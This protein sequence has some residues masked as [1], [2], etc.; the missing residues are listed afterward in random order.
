MNTISKKLKLH[1]LKNGLEPKQAAMILNV[2]E[3]KYLSFEN[4]NSDISVVQLLRLC[5]YYGLDIAGFMASNVKKNDVGQA[6]ISIAAAKVRY[7]SPKKDAKPVKP[8]WF[9]AGI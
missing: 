4:G 7:S 6:V 8:Y 2:T 3:R 1:R 9:I 5:E